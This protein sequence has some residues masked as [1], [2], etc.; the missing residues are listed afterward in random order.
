MII[1]GKSAEKVKAQELLTPSCCPSC[2]TENALVG[3]VLMRYMHIWYIPF[4][5]L[6]KR[7]VA[8]C[9]HCKGNFSTMTLGTQ[10]ALACDTLKKRAK[11]PFSYWTLTIL[12]AGLF[13]LVGLAGIFGH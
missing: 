10:H 11:Y 9:R 2:K 13:A 7:V 1:F 6:E 4:F 3:V 8:V 12:F 5:P